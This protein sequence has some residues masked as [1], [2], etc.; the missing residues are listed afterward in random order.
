MGRYAS[1]RSFGHFF[2]FNSTSSVLALCYRT[3]TNVI[4]RHGK[5][6]ANVGIHGVSESSIETGNAHDQPE[7]YSLSRFIWFSGVICYMRL[8]SGYVII[9]VARRTTC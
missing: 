1:F 3:K 5:I 4:S 2:L 6:S 9:Q 7:F 8:S